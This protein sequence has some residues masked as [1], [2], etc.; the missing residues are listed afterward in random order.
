[1]ESWR[2]F[3]YLPLGFFPA[4]FFT[5]RMLVQWL[6]SE[7]Q[8]KSLVTPLFWKLSLAGNLL[9]YFHYVIQ[10]QLHYA[11]F[12]CINALIAWRNL[13]FLK[14]DKKAYPRK[15]VFALLAL[16]LLGTVLIFAL[17]GHFLLEQMDW[18]RTPQNLWNATKRYH[19]LSW[20]VF[21]AFGAAL[22]ASRFWVQWWIAEF[23]QRSALG[24][25]YWL[26]S[27]AGSS[28]VLLYSWHIRDVVVIFYHLFSLIPYLRN[29]MLLRKQVLRTSKKTI[30]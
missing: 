27:I 7:R 12:Q 18:V 28:M 11:L 26:L 29:L 1:M 17:Q 14:V 22:F 30:S 10:V 6:Q 4:I 16:C 15:V 19:S 5:S 23:H 21:G 8:K 13:D 9:L 25:S 3:L 24:R 2:T 20:H